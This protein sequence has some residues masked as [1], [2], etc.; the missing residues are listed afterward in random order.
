MGELA[1]TSLWST[2]EYIMN[3]VNGI[4]MEVVMDL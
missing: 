4:V 2:S 3:E 1:K